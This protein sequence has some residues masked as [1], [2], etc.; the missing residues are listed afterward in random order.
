P[1]LVPR[2][3]LLRKLHIRRTKPHIL[4]FDD[5]VLTCG[6]FRRYS[7]PRC[8]GWGPLFGRR[9]RRGSFR[10]GCFRSRRRGR[11]GFQSASGSSFRQIVLVGIKRHSYTANLLSARSSFFPFG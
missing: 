8:R 4:R 3:R 10:F 7:L 11:W 5:L 6:G 1:E 2:R 9:F